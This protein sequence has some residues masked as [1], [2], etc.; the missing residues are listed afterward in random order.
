MPC[1][2]MLFVFLNITKAEIL[3][4]CTFPLKL[5]PR[6]LHSSAKQRE[7]VSLFLYLIE[8]IIISMVQGR[9]APTD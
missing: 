4:S 8:Y 9:S 3:P 2:K 7:L 6:Y 5:K 1:S